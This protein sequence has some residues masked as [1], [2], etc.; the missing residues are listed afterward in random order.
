MN[1]KRIVFHI[2]D[3]F[4]TQNSITIHTKTE[5]ICLGNKNAGGVTLS[6]KNDRFFNNLI[7]SGNLGLG[8][9]YINNDFEIIDGTLPDLL[10][11]LLAHRLDQ[12]IKISTQIVLRVVATRLLDNFKGKANNI[13][14]HYDIGIEIFKSMLD[15]SLTYSCGFLKNENDSLSVLQQNK[16]ERITNKIN[17]ADGETVLDIGCGYGGFLVY[18]A[19]KFNVSGTGITNSK[20]HKEYAEKIISKKQLK[21]KV[22]ITLGDYKEA[23][24]KY[25]KVVSIGM[26]EH[27]PRKEYKAYFSLIRNILNPDGTSLVHFVGCNTYKNIHDPF[28]QKYIFPNS[29]QP[30]LSEVAHNVEQQRM[31]IID[32]EN[33][34]RHYRP[35]ARHW[36][37]NFKANKEK[38]NT[39]NYPESFQRMWEYYLACCVSAARYSDSAVYQVLISHSHLKD[40]PWKRV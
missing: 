39:T 7:A 11:I 4:I 12:K 36:L 6:V 23:E 22:N 19:E 32:V 28:I 14:K 31:A 1:N 33:I 21:G 30:K 24:G 37:N 9:S 8:E 40:I 26:L 17:L 34:I 16:Y 2:L 3:N 20:Q 10:D 15:E 18:C 13:K 38:I 35:T 29:N 27:V 25:D 5:S